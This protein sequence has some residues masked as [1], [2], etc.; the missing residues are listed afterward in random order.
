[1][2]RW[3]RGGRSGDPREASFGGGSPKG[4]SLGRRIEIAA[5]AIGI[6]AGGFLLGPKVADLFGAE[7]EIRL[8]VAEPSVSNPRP[9]TSGGINRVSAQDPRVAVTVRNLGTATAWIEEA[10]ITIVEGA[11]LRVC[12]VQGGGDVP[13]TNPYRITLPEF[14]G[15]DRQLVRRDL[16]VEVQPGHGVRP[17]LSF[18][19]EDIGTTNLYAIA[20]EL[21]ADPGGHVYDAGRFVIG[22]P[23]PVSRFG[24]VLPESEEVLTSDVTSP[25]EVI[26]TWCFR[27]NLAAMRRVLVEP[28]F[29][30]AEVAALDHVQLAPGWNAYAD[31][32]PTQLAV[33]ELLG[34]EDPEAALDA[35]EV[36][37]RSDDPGLEATVRK[38]AIAVLLRQGRREL[39]SYPPNA[40][41][42]AER[43]LSLG[44]SSAASRLLWRAK[45][46][47]RAE[48]ELAA[49]G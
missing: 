23:G 25:G 26:P 15:E 39:E 43:V 46:A 31:H 33:E 44:Q 48:D 16:H 14:P 28:G 49:A 38:R 1:M 3:G 29:R 11:R 17:V 40:V 30:S 27:H 4:P 35:I 32:S 24:G 34:S 10:R 37:R 12:V 21:V 47:V 45:A 8:E 36:A 7:E 22:V 19:K 13:R 2:T 9:G 6:L 20:V 41:A 42:N 5:A 18:Q